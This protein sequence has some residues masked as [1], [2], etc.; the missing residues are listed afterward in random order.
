M[1]A[2]APEITARAV[3]L[4][5]PGTPAYSLSPN[6][7]KHW[8]IQRQESRDAKWRVR[9]VYGP[10]TSRLVPHGPVALTWTVFLAK[11]GRKRD[12]DNLVPC[13]KP[14]MDSLVDLEILDGDTP[15]IVQRIEVAQV[16]WSQ[17]HGDPMLC[18]TIE[19][20]VTQ[21]R[22]ETKADANAV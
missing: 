2:D 7:R 21:R 14:F 6:S 20:A 13:M 18:V 5:I 8:R 9:E 12:V 15:D 19:S 1:M 3:T 17:H 10:Y 16:P 11:G 22:E 4:T